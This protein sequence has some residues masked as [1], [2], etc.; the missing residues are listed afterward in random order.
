VTRWATALLL[1]AACGDDPAPDP[2]PELCTGGWHVCGGALRDADG[3]TVIL[4]GMN[5]SS[6]NKVAPYLDWHTEA[7]FARMRDDWGFNAIRW[8]MPWAAVEP[9]QGDYD[10]AYLAAVRERLDWA[11]AH[12]ILVVL[13]MHQDVYGEGF[14]FDGAPRW[15]CDEARY[16]DFELREPWPLN[17][18]DDNVVACFDELWMDPAKGEAFAAAWAHVAA[19]LGDHPAVNGFDVINEPHWGS[20]PVIDFERDLLQPFYDRVVAAVRAEAPGWVAFLEPAASRNLGFPT[21]LEPF[22]YADVVYAPHAYDATA[23]QGGGFDPERR[24][25][26]MRNINNLREEADRL[27]AALWIGEYGGMNDDP[28]LGAYMAAAYDGA[29]AVGASTMYWDYGRGG[30]Y[31]P[32]DADGNEIPAVIDA[33]ARS[34]PS[35]IA[36]DL[37]D[38]TY[39]DPPDQAATFTVRWRPDPRITAPTEIIL[40]DDD[41]VASVACNDCAFE[42][43]G[44]VFRLTVEP[45]PD[46][47]G[48]ATLVITP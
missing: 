25:S 18:L 10:D 46:D 11:E 1:V 23:E 13:D 32:L 21:T 15:T 24:D 26:F 28:N 34:Y 6:G 7:D 19:A 12:G 27:G 22:A 40:L 30:G 35:R 33:I 29:G 9:A 17:Y 43:D 36:G 37:V 31:H 20:T 44:D 38:Y 41:D 5:V 3:R 8:V 4:R 47:D 14:G 45:T 2:E 48:V 42:M 39:V 16:A